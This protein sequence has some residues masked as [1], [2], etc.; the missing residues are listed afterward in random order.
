MCQR[1]T[2]FHWLN[3][4]DCKRDKPA[5]LISCVLSS[6][7]APLWPVQEQRTSQRITISLPNVVGNNKPPP[8]NP[9]KL[10]ITLVTHTHSGKLLLD[11][12]RF[13][14]Q[15]RNSTALELE[16][17]KEKA[18]LNSY[19]EHL[20]PR[21]RP[22][23]C[24]QQRCDDEDDDNDESDNDGYPHCPLMRRFVPTPIASIN[25]L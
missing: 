8:E 17:E 19:V 16:K 14:M 4:L 2:R 9:R 10:V 11:Q 21:Q 7:W 24:Q 22:S 23:I 13:R 20:W 25:A 1:R 12:Q 5:S 18:N 15:W 6:T 3:L